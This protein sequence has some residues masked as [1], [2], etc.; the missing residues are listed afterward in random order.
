MK[1]C[2][3]RYTLSDY[4]NMYITKQRMNAYAIALRRVVNSNSVVIDVGTGVGFFALL[5]CRLGARHVYAIEPDDAINLGRKIAVTNDYS[6]RVTFIQDISSNVIL[7]ERADIIISDLTGA[8]P[9]HGKGIPSIIDARERLLAP[10]GTL[11]PQQDR[12]W[13]VVV[14]A[15]DGYHKLMQPWS[16]NLIG[17][18]LSGGWPLVAN[19]PTR[20]KQMRFL[21]PPTMVAVLDY[22]SIVDSDVEVK[23][24][25]TIEQPGAGHGLAVW[26]DRTLIDGV[27]ISNA[28]DAQ[29]SINTS[30][31]HGQLFFPWPHP[32]EL[33]RGDDVCVT[34]K[35][36]LI[37]ANYLWRWESIIGGKTK[38]HFCQ[39]SLDAHPLSLG[40]LRGREAGYVPTPSEDTLIDA[41]VLSRVDGRASLGEL[42]KALAMNFPSRFSNWEDALSRVA[43]IIAEY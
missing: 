17:L 6:D 24:V 40:S 43:D 5:A 2:A 39:S 31:L 21:A 22:R 7:S 34:L 9:L 26:F 20:L 13:A 11:I 15:S 23:L 42:S 25:W 36:N 41:F 1:R 27:E 19:T 32:V 37:R 33:S 4:G 16:A 30:S 12:L 10:G 8:L 29:E 28:P 35:A 14:E 3:E 38:V 18:D